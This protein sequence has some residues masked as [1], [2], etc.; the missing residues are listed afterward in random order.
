MGAADDAG[1]QIALHAIGDRANGVALDLWERIAVDNGRRDRR[2]RIEHAQHLRPSD[3]ERFARTGVIASVQ[4]Y[5]CLDDGRW[6]EKRIGKERARSAYAFRSLL[7][8]GAVVVFGSDWWVAPMNPLLTIY[9]AVTRRTLDGKHPEGWF[10]EQKVSVAE[11]VHAC[12]FQG[13][14]ASGEENLKGS[15]EPGKL[16]DAVVLSDD[17]FSIDP[18][19]IQ[20]VKVDM[21]I[22]DGKVVFERT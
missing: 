6:I 9:A 8:A 17:I 2:A 21:T 22:L 18:A 15:L 1:L 10:P 20:A 7:D 16:A 19:A 5:H 12:T 13:A 11:A 4:P 14:Y 3:F